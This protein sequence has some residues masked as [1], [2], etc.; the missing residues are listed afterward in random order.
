MLRVWNLSLLLT[1][2][3][4]HPRHVPHPVGRAR[5]CARVHRESAIGPM[6]LGF[7]GLTVAVGV[8]PHRLAR[9]PVALAR[10]GSTPRS[11]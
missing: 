4:H 8:G 2:L 9:R 11:R 1:L 5:L 3:A 7:F 6:I 10:L